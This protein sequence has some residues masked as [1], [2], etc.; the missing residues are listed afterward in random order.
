LRREDDEVPLGTFALSELPQGIKSGDI[1]TLSFS[2]N[3]EETRAAAE[4]VRALHERL[5]KKNQ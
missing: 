1:L 5:L 4:R 2:I 3:E